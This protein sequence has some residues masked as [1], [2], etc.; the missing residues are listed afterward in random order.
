MSAW[1][2]RFRDF[3]FVRY[4][5]QKYVFTPKRNIT[6][7]KSVVKNVPFQDIKKEGGLP[8]FLIINYTSMICWIPFSSDRHIAPSSGPSGAKR[9]SFSSII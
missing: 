4:Y 2:G 3:C 7:V 8:S 6:V 9:Y 5:F 1:N